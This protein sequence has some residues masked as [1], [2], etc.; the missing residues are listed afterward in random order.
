MSIGESFKI[1]KSLSSNTSDVT[2]SFEKLSS[3]KRINRASDDAAGLAIVNALESDVRT[4]LQGARNA[5]DGVSVASI[6]DGSLSQISDITARQ[7]ELATQA[8]NGT[9]TDTQRQSLNAEFQQLDQEKGRIL[10][11]STFNGVNVF[12]GETLQV[13]T[14]GS[15][16]SQINIPSVNTASLTGS[17]DISTAGAASSAIDALK[18]QSDSLGKVRGDIGASVS[19]LDIAENNARTKST[20]SDAAA[21][22]IRDLDVADETSKL[23]AAT[24][25]QHTDVALSAQ[26]GKLNAD[27]VLKLLN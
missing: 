2:K 11:T 27:T 9:L 14:D 17:L 19:R 6:A 1:G 12:S 13:G 18:T 20:E 24:I 5:V 8:A 7:S 21:A 25:R 16:S 22:R 15:S 4:S 23:T 3:G 26:A 10:Q